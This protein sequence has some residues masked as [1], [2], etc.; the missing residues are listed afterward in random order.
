MA[1]PET[2]WLKQQTF[3]SHSSEG[4]EVQGQVVSRERSLPGSQKPS[5]Y[6]LCIAKGIKE[7]SGV[8]FYKGLKL[9]YEGLTVRT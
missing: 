5:S 3:I 4:Q 6:C 1:I 7:V 9:T 2:G 8:S